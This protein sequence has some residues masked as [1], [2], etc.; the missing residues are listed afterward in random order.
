VQHSAL[1]GSGIAGKKDESFSG[2]DAETKGREHFLIGE[3]TVKE[4]GIWQVFEWRW[5]LRIEWNGA[6]TGLHGFYSYPLSP[7]HTR[8]VSD[9]RNEVE[10]KEGFLPAFGQ[11]RGVEM[12]ICSYWAT[13]AP[14]REVF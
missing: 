12:T 6:H 13:F 14:L 3:I 5:S 2:F 9:S 1:A 4:A 11:N 10:S 8:M 7:I